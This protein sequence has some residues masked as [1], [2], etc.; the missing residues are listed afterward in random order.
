MLWLLSILFFGISAYVGRLVD[1]SSQIYSAIV[2]FVSFNIALTAM[3]LQTI[4]NKGKTHNPYILKMNQDTKEKVIKNL[5]I[6]KMIFVIVGFI[7]TFYIFT[8][9]VF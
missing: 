7:V 5:F 9:K 4:K 8:T 6:N 2:I 3:L 1:L